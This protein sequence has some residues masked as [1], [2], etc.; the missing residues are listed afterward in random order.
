MILIGGTMK[1]IKLGVIITLI[2]G[3]VGCSGGS[4]DEVR[5]ITEKLEKF[6]IVEEREDLITFDYSNSN[7]KS[8]TITYSKENVFVRIEDN[9]ID[10]LIISIDGINSLS[11]KGEISYDFDEKEVR[12]YF[13]E[14]LAG[15][16][17]LSY[18][19]E[20]A[21][22]LLNKDGEYYEISEE[23]KDILEENGFLEIVEN[24]IKTFEN[25]LNDNDLSLEEITNLK[26]N[27]IK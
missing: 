19:L 25:D 2:A 5:K 21:S 12:L 24:D 27:D 11:R 3:L 4:S 23:F 10:D 13:D 14:D 15:I 22:Y 17:I 8:W 6:T 9:R 26:Y 16:S 20:D 7:D 18:N 1:K